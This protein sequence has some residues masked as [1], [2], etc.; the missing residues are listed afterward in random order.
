M[1]RRIL[2]V[3]LVPVTLLTGYFNEQ[4]PAAYKAV[5]A[6]DAAQTHSHFV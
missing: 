4:A 5:S 2:C 1:I 3:I 6:Q